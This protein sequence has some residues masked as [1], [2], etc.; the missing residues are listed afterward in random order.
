MFTRIRSAQAAAA[1]GAVGLTLGLAGCAAKVRRDEFT[2]E[3]ARLREEMQAGDR[4]VGA[5]VDSTNLAVADHTRRLAALEQELQSFRSEYN[6]SMEKVNDMLKF[7]VPV[8][9]D[10]AASELREADRPVLDRFSSVVKRYYPGAIVTVEGFTDPA[11]SVAYN[12]R[13]GQ[14]RADAVKEYLATAGGFTSETLKAVSYGEARNRQVVPGAR[15]P[16]DVGVENRRVAL[17]IDHAA[18]ATDDVATR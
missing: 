6:V 7:D 11:G 16:G 2:T 15:G 8:H 12:R 17:V 14:R 13:L 1:L 18:V 10:F 9:F 4:Q 3:V 5:R